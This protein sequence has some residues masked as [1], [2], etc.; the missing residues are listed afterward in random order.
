MSKKKK[1]SVYFSKEY[2]VV[3][4]DEDQALLKTQQHLNS[5]K[6]KF[7][8]FKHDVS[9]LDM[10]HEKICGRPKLTDGVDIK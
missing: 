7:K 9:E 6:D 10:E 8:E 4:E 5:P 3:A 1:F 2:F